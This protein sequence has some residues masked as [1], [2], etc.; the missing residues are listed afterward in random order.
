GSIIA[1]DVTFS[2]FYSNPLFLNPALTGN[3]AC[4]RITINYRNQWPSL[5]HAYNTY[6]LSFDQSLPGI[7]SGYGINITSDQQ[8]NNTISNNQISG[9]YSYHLQAGSELI[10]HAGLQVSFHMNHIN[11]DKLIFADQIDINGDISS[12][13]TSGEIT[14][15]TDKN[16]LDFSGGLAFG[17]MD[18]YYGGLAVHHMTEPDNSF[19]DDKDGFLP[20]RITLHGGAIFDMNNGRYSKRKKTISPNILFQQQGKFHQ[21]NTGLYA[22]I[23]PFIIGGWF[24]HNFENPDAAIIL[25][26]LQINELNIGYS[27]D[28]TLSEIRGY[29]GGAH[30][31]SLSYEFC[32]YHEKRRKIRAIKCPK[33]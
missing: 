22:N 33:F 28:Y 27:Y 13:N 30:E 14:G 3:T 32:I 4:G 9:L 24:R 17:Y 23:E 18:K 2:Q 10:I 26:G 8:A 6:N 19:T 21:I 1:Q 5:S 11:W 31:I 12:Y 16:F 29:S 15:D 7:S 20:M 25:L